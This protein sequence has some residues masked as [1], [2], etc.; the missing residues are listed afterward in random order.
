MNAVASP[1]AARLATI[2][3]EQKEVS[4]LGSTTRYWEYGDADAV[5]TIL[6][7]HGYRG[8]HH[9]LEPVIAHLPGYRFISPDLP[10]FGESTPL[11]ET[12]HS[13]AG[14]GEWLREFAERVGVTGTAII[15]GHSFGTIVTSAAVAGG[16]RTPA[17]ILINP[18]AISG[19]DGPRRFATGLTVAYYRAAAKLPRRLGYALLNNWLVVQFMSSAL[20]KTRDKALKKWIDREHHTYFN[21]FTDRDTVVEAFD[22]SISADVSSVAARIAV[23]TL[24]VA[25]ELD[26]IT[27]ISA[28][29]TLQRSIPDAR[30]RVLGGVGH[31]IHYEA[32]DRAA[33]AIRDFVDALPRS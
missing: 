16:M 11:T 1:Y 25:A 18:I 8:E 20:T 14:Y 2:P 33:D 12:S 9:G 22:A 26:D 7:V 30:L 31:L 17:L 6:V 23:P 29:Y 4:V 10:G 5:W 27:P 3:V 24:L 13:I 21:R 28:Q 15:L 32:P 19:L